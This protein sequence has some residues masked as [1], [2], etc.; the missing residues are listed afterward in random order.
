MKFC[1]PKNRNISSVVLQEKAMKTIIILFVTIIIAGSFVH[2]QGIT[3]LDIDS[4]F[5][6]VGCPQ[7][8]LFEQLQAWAE[9]S[10][11]DPG[12]K[13][14]LKR[15]EDFSIEGV[16]QFPVTYS[17][18]TQTKSGGVVT[19]K[20]WLSA[21]TDRYRVIFSDFEHK[22]TEGTDHGSGGALGQPTP[23]KLSGIFKATWRNYQEQA[24]EHVQKQILSVGQFVNEVNNKGDW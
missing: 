4:V 9:K 17:F 1:S 22:A 5:V 10:Y 23:G 14:M 21:R 11:N 24:E 2:G 15:L 8:K 6:R 7:D 20:F 16:G 3:K 12:N 13:V 19:Y 18:L